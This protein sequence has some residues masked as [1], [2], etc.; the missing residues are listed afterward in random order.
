MNDLPESLFTNPIWNALQTKHRHFAVSAGDA[1]RYPADVAPF[2]AVAEPTSAALQRLHSLLVPGESVWLIG[3]SYP[4]AP[5][6]FLEETLEALQMVLPE[7]VAP[8]D[9][10]HKIVSLSA[11][12]AQEMVELTDIAFP[13]FFRKRTCEMGSYY[14]V[15]SDAMSDG[16]LIA[17]SGERL[18]L[19]GYSEISGVCTHPAHRGK[20]LAASLMWQLVRDHRRDGFVSWLHVGSENRGAVELYLRMG[21]KKVREITLHRVSRKN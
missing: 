19:D 11:A 8:P 18:I 14:G 10:M 21:F 12:N 4:Q 2:V 13:G 9:P 15:R 5:A 3:K 6:L 7:E 16:K 1:C 17:M 20:G